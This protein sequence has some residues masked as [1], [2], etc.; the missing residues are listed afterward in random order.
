MPPDQVFL[1]SILSAGCIES[2][3]LNPVR[4]DGPP[5]GHVF[6]DLPMARISILSMIVEQDRPRD[7]VSIQEK[8]N[9]RAILKLLSSSLTTLEISGNIVEFPTLAE[10]HW[11][12]LKTL[13]MTDRIPDGTVIPLP[14]VVAHMPLLKSLSYDFIAS[15]EFQQRAIFC[16][17]YSVG[18]SFFAFPKLECLSISNVQPGDLLVEQL[19]TSLK[20]LRVCALRY[21]FPG[22][23]VDYSRA[24]HYP[25]TPLNAPETL[26]WLD[27]TKSL[28]DLAELAL[29][30]EDAPWPM[31]LNTI[32]SACPRLRKLELEKAKFEENIE[33]SPYRL[34]DFLGP[35]SLLPHLSH[36][37]FTYEFGYH[38]TGMSASKLTGEFLAA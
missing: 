25:Y 37:R 7:I 23:Q 11:P 3:R 18:T 17:E 24:V 35:L 27:A 26:R 29:T 22:W 30:T 32:A 4:L 5:L 38:D 33:K 9:V 20:V 21:A 8:N 31:L 34:N 36:L 28:Q 15:V 19:P 2:L 1:R 13:R 10:T 12:Q 14:I 16:G 6:T